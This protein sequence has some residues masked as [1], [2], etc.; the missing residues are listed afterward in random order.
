MCYVL[1]IQCYLIG[2]LMTEGNPDKVGYE[3]YNF[4]LGLRYTVIRSC[5]QIGQLT[6]SRT[7]MTVS[8]AMTSITQR[9]KTP[10]LLN[11][12]LWHFFRLPRGILVKQIMI[13][14]HVLQQW[15]KVSFHTYYI[16]G[17]SV[18]IS[19]TCDT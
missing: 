12:A 2:V 19:L 1:K 4:I 13:F 5:K 14:F 8:R 6:T 7:V 17:A 3:I 18:V 10:Y 11:S 16:F 9:Q 15:L